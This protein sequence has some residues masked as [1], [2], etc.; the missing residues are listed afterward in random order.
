MARRRE[1][2]RTQELIERE[3]EAAAAEAAGIGGEPGDEDLDPAE[4]PVVESGGGEAEGFE[5]AE[6]D[7]RE[8]AEHGEGGRSAIADSYRQ[9]E[10]V[11]HAGAEHGEADEVDTTEGESDRA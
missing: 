10:E 4:R 9:A 3:T 7:L 1:R 5:L 8:Q 2:D 6:E 11:E